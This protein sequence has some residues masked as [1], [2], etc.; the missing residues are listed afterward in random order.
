MK[1]K[2]VGFILL[3]VNFFNVCNSEK[4]LVVVI[5]SYNNSQWYQ[6]NLDSVF[7]QQ[8]NNY[9][10]IYLDDC[11]SD[12]TGV[13]VEE[14]IKQRGFEDKVILIKNTERKLALANIY[15]AVHSCDDEEI[16]L[17][18]DG[19]DSFAHDKVMQRINQAYQNENVWLTYGNF[20]YFFKDRGMYKS[21]STMIDKKLIESNGYRDDGSAMVSHLRTFYAALFKKIKKEDLLYQGDFYSMCYDVAIMIPMLEMSG[22]KFEFIPDV[23]YLYNRDNVIND[24]KV[25][26]DLQLSLDREVRSKSKYQPLSSLFH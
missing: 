23:L 2:L 10:V 20:S 13:L 19:D 25:N 4:P 5:P 12:G 26:G 7:R 16:I 6:W 21:R 15:Y 1:L 11:S 24:D 8:Y 9:R 22:G 18:L 17:I 3:L 14:Y